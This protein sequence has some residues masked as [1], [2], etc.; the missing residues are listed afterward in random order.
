ML[1]TFLVKGAYR[2]PHVVGRTCSIMI[3]ARTAAAAMRKARD[4]RTWF[5]PASAIECGEPR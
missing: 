3:R 5:E 4:C 1:E 2:L